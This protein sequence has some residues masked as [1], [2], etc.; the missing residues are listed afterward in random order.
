MIGKKKKKQPKVEITTLQKVP[1]PKRQPNAKNSITRR[2]FLKAYEHT[3]GNISASCEYAGIQRQTYYRWI[4]SNTEVNIKFQQA[5]HAIRPYERLKDLAEAVVVQNLNAGSLSAAT[6]VLERIATD[7]GYGKQVITKDEFEQV[8]KAVQ[9]LQK[10]V[11][12]KTAKDPDW[13]FDLRTYAE[14]AAEDFNVPVEAIEKEFLKR[15]PQTLGD[16]G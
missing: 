13:K 4:K 9:R 12:V 14:I 16:I 10:V 7:R 5:L 8:I 6:F 2:K 1:R 3:M 15:Q 11:E